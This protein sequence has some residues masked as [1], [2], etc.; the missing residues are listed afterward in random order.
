MCSHP[1]LGE[2]QKNHD[3]LIGPLQPDIIKELVCGMDDSQETCWT[4]VQTMTW[5]FNTKQGDQESLTAFHKRLESQIQVTESVWGGQ[6]IPATT[7]AK[8]NATKTQATGK[9]FC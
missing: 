2:A 7:T 6:L 5:L 8:N 9:V 4:V 3:I 1:W